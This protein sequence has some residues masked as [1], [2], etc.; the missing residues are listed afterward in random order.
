MAGG[1]IRKRKKVTSQ[2]TTPSTKKPSTK[3]DFAAHDS[4]DE[5]SDHE[6]LRS[7]N[8]RRRKRLNDVDINSDDEEED[9]GGES[10]DD[11]SEE[12]EI[13]ETVDEKRVRLAREYLRSIEKK[14][15]D[16]DDGSS[17]EEEEE[18][19]T[20]SSDAEGEDEDKFQNKVGMKLARERMKREGTLERT[21]ADRVG[22]SVEE[23]SVGTATLKE[24][25]AAKAWVA[26][27]H[28]KY[29]RG[30][31]LTVTCV[32]LHCSGE[33]AY[34][35]SKDGSVCMWDVETGTRKEMVVPKW[36]RQEQ[37]KNQ[38]T[39]HR[40]DGEVLAAAC[41]DD[42]RYLAVG[43]R[44]A[45][46]RIFDIRVSKAGKGLRGMVTSF[47]GHKGPVTCL[48]FRDQSLQLF[49]GSD[50]RCIRH[51]NLEEMAYIETLYGHQAGITGIDCHRNERPI[52]TGRDRTAR[53]WKI[54]EDSHLI[55]RGGS[56]VSSA[57]CVSCL[58]DDW[59]LSGHDDGKLSLWM[60]DKK[61]A[62]ATV[63]TAHGFFGSL[64]RGVTSCCAL[65]SSDLAV[66]GS[67]DGYMRLWKVRSCKF[68]LCFTNMSIG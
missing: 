40:A 15:D 28:A 37:E 67:N 51:Y 48:A 13:S 59:F 61:K 66:T 47:K 22:A 4:S 46:T 53:S 54:A 2:S 38:K 16:D 10:E 39:V 14:V 57:D 3:I 5:E 63:D 29:L 36:S 31:D 7:S 23:R 19:E 25:E 20:A 18:D 21:I 17:S 65:K 44:D 33:V 27:G 62:V 41:S 68:V 12:E 35:G 42:G 56:R 8:D 50:D 64:P 6:N 24:E 32:A 58:K 60:T 26:A 1:S 34:S 9:G 11:E 52:S 55:F 43:M 45:T 30:H 49:S